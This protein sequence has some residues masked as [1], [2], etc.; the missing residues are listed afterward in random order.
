MSNYLFFALAVMAGY[1]LGSMSF[2]VLVSRVMG[3]SDPR[4]Y[5]SGNPGATNVLRSG[6]K[7]AALLTLLGD[8]LKGSLAVWLVQRW[9]APYGLHQEA[10][11]VVGLAAFIGHL[12]PI[13]FR[14]KGG[15]GVATFFGVLLVITPQIGLVAALLWLLMAFVSRYSS[16]ASVCA[17]L[18]APIFYLVRWGG[19]GLALALLVM[20]ALLIWRHRQN[21]KNLFAG[22]ERKLGVKAG[23]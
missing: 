20:S 9:G 4:T 10:A 21:I 13:F 3:L 19:D 8:A 22:T 12:Y 18:I 7:L 14:F 1:L 15:K 5:G 17:A 2:A 6:S 11:A 16:L 23:S